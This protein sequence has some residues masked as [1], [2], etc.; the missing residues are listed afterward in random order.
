[1]NFIQHEIIEKQRIE[2]PD[3]GIPIGLGYSW[4]ICD[5]VLIWNDSPIQ[6]SLS[7]RET[8]S[9]FIFQNELT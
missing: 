7:Q 3:M 5:E 9:F 6:L 4:D 1:M 2:F 8:G